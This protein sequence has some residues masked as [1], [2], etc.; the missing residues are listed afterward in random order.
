METPTSAVDAGKRLTRSTAAA[1]L[2]AALAACAPADPSVTLEQKLL[3][4]EQGTFAD[5]RIAAC[6]AALTASN[7]DPL[8]RAN[9]LVQRGMLRAEQ[10]HYGRAVADFGRA[11]RIDATNADALAERGAVHQMRGSYDFAMRD[12]QAALAID[13]DHF[14][15]AYRRDQAMQ[16]RGDQVRQQ[17]A[18]L[19]EALERDPD[20]SAMLNNRCWIRAVNDE[21]LNAAL[22]DCNAAL[23]TA[24]QSAAALDSR[25]LVH[26]KR[27]DYQAALADYE[28]ALRLQPQRGHFLFGRGL[29]RVALGQVEE[30]KG[31]LAAA[32]T[33]EP[34][35][36]RAYAEYG[37]TPAH[38]R[39]AAQPVDQVAV[40]EP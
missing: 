16:G 22:H 36:A 27:G 25:G 15:A 6:T 17:I 8:Q 1:A 34:G 28:A 5:Q 19:T 37:Y 14:I 26:L 39:R 2:S 7:L 38:A 10:G 32:E 24:P 11:L 21:D 33:A 20:N 40:I 3:Q 4:C 30:G 9:A 18:R 29:A 31:D 12:F 35:V 23:R 13:P